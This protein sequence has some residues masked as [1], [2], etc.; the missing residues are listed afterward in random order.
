MYLLINLVAYVEYVAVRRFLS[1]QGICFDA[2]PVSTAS[3]L[4]Q[5]SSFS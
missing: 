4:D 1:F 3:V 5:G 2:L